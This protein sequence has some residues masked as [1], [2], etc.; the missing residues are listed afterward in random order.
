MSVPGFA[1]V[2]C[3]EATATVVGVGYG[4]GDGVG[5][6]AEATATVGAAALCQPWGNGPRIQRGPLPPGSAL[7]ID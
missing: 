2:V 6:G 3:A 1:P 4:V 5:Y 7:I